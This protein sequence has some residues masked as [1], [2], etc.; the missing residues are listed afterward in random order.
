MHAIGDRAIVKQRSKHVLH[1]D[2]H[3]IEALHV[4]EC[5]LLPGEGGIRHIFRRGGGTDG[6]GGLGII[7]GQLCIGI[8]NGVFQFA[9]ERRIND[10]LTDLSARFR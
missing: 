8:T 10:P 2:E 6:K 7:R 1:R 5:L 3:G 9:L 4:E